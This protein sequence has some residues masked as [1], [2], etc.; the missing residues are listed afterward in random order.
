MYHVTTAIELTF[1]KLGHGFKKV[2]FDIGDAWDK[3]FFNPITSVCICI[4]GCMVLR[5]CIA[6]TLVLVLAP[7]IIIDIT[8]Y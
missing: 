1:V 7:N 6:F 4:T 2:F 5:L 8:F 3:V